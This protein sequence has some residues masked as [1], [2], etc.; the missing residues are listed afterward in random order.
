MLHEGFS[1]LCSQCAVGLTQSA[2]WDTIFLHPCVTLRYPHKMKRKGSWGKQS[3]S[4]CCKCCLGVVQKT[5]THTYG[6]QKGCAGLEL[7]TER[8]TD[9]RLKQKVCRVH[10]LVGWGL[11]LVGENCCA[12][13]RNTSLGEQNG[14]RLGHTMHCRSDVGL[15]LFVSCRSLQF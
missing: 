3:K 5:A 1:S 10:M 7:S 12:D 8:I 2:S 6:L 14:T 13:S 9:H 4:M 15:T 11:V